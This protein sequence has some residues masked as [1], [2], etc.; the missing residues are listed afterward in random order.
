MKLCA[1]AGKSY[2]GKTNGTYLELENVSW[3]MVKDSI[4][5]LE[6]MSLNVMRVDKCE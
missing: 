2:K 1:K 6:M 4:V 5:S 3:E